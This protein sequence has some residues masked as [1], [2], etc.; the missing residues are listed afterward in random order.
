VKKITVNE[1]CSAAEVCN[2]I[3]GLKCSQ[4]GVCKCADNAHWKD[5]KCGEFIILVIV[6]RIFYFNIV[7][8]SSRKRSCAKV[9]K[10]RR[11]RRH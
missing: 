6:L 5:D 4:D 3:V 11:M 7:L 10:E 2:D 8:N 9:R 1:K